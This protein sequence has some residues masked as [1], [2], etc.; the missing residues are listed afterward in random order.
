MKSGFI[1]PTDKIELKPHELVAFAHDYCKIH[2]FKDFKT[3]AENIIWLI[4]R[5]NMFLK[6]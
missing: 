6:Y 2:D 5:T 1:T 4:R 3:F